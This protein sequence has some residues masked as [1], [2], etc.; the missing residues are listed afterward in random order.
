[1][2]NPYKIRKPLDSTESSGFSQPVGGLF[3]AGA[4]TFRRFQEFAEALQGRI[5]LVI[6]WILNLKIVP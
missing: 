6:I 2:W 3:V 4:V 1:L 5:N